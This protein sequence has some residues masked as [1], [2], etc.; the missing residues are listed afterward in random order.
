MHLTAKDGVKITHEYERVKAL[1]E[2]N[3][4][5]VFVTGKAG[6]GKSTLIQYLRK[7]T[8]RKCVVLAPTGVAAM[9]VQG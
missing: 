1:I 4:P 3:A 7:N 5:L 2:K 9:N 6:T 8:R